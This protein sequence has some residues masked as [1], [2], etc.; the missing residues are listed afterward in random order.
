ALDQL[1]ELAADFSNQDAPCRREA[2]AGDVAGAVVEYPD[3]EIHLGRELRH[4]LA[5]VSAAHDEQRDPRQDRQG[6]DAPVQHGGRAV[7]QRV[8]VAGHRLGYG[9][10]AELRRQPAGL[11]EEV[12][13][14]DG[15]AAAVVG[16]DRFGTAGPLLDE[17]A[18]A[19]V[20]GEHI[21]PAAQRGGE[22]VHAA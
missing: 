4:R 12:A 10:I 14:A 18:K 16:R 2:F 6:G 3:L 20:V 5:D 15:G 21:V 13:S 8:Q 19:A 17:V 7:A 22:D 9:A 1:L 11:V